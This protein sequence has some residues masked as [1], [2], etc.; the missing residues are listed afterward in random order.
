MKTI[1]SR[2]PEAKAKPSGVA[3]VGCSQIRNELTET[4]STSHRNLCFRVAN[5]NAVRR[6][7]KRNGY[8]DPEVVKKIRWGF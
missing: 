5:S 4:S 3:G 7:Q 1:S 6:F 2:N 8:L